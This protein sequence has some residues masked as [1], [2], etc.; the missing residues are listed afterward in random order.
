MENLQPAVDILADF[1]ATV[2]SM[3]FVTICDAAKL[4]GCSRQTIW[5]HIR[6]GDLETY[7][8]SRNLLEKDVK[9]LNLN[10]YPDRRP[11]KHAT[12]SPLLQVVQVD[13]WSG[14][15][16]QEVTLG[17]ITSVALGAGS[18]AICLERNLFPI[19]S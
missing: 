19:P 13:I 16:A 14:D 1:G 7:G 9:A 11:S 10:G 8:K 4:L 6:N 2:A 15:L 18:P 5:R 3:R 17:I 12:P